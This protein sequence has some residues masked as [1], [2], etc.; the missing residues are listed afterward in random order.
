MAFAHAAGAQRLTGTVRDS[1]SRLPC[2]GVIVILLDSAGGT[3]S[4]DSRTSAA[5]IACYYMTRRG[6]RGSFA[7]ASAARSS[8]CRL[9]RGARNAVDAAMFAL[10]S[11][12]QPIHVRANSRCRARKDRAEALG[13][14]E[15]AR[16]G[17]LATIVARE[18]NPATMSS[19]S[20][21][22]R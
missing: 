15:Q 8:D 10:P 7:S 11:L 1:V 19:V 12:I 20:A 17:L 2:P 13:L 16:A 3:V 18:E 9:Y 22:T 21:S 14:W 5:S 6:A 4:R